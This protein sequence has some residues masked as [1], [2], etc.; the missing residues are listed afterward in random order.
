MSKVSRCEWGGLA[1]YFPQRVA[2][3]WVLE[4]EA[5]LQER[6][7]HN[8]GAIEEALAHLAHRELKNWRGHREEGRA[9]EGASEFPGELG[10]TYRIRSRGVPDSRNF[11]IDCV[12][13]NF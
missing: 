10:V 1:N 6:V 8:F 9:T 11:V 13:E 4:M 7:R 5:R 2:Q 12:G 3:V